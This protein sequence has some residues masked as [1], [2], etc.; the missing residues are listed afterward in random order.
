MNIDKIMNLQYRKV[1]TKKHDVIDYLI[2]A[3][4]YKTTYVEFNDIEILSFFIIDLDNLNYPMINSD[5]FELIKEYLNNLLE[6]NAYEKRT[7]DIND[8]K[9]IFMLSKKYRVS[10]ELNKT[11]TLGYAKYLNTRA[12]DNLLYIG[13]DML[14]SIL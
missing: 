1:L 4:K 5:D 3:E 10:D 9:K 2:A 8:I 7:F 6:D 14:E 12:D 11:I 13:I